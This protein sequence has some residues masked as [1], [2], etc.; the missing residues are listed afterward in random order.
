MVLMMTFST[1]K[2]Y[3]IKTKKQYRLLKRSWN[4][5][6]TSSGEWVIINDTS[7]Q[8]AYTVPFTLVHAGKYRAEDKLKIQTIQ[9]LNTTQKNQTMQNSKTNLCW[10]SS[11]VW[12]SAARKWGGLI[13]E[14][15]QALYPH[16]AEDKLRYLFRAIHAND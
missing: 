12:H 15:S 8:V 1:D 10:F 5:E 7:A 6:K 11:L 13:L 14:H 9:K 4:L 2:Q 3:I 16:G